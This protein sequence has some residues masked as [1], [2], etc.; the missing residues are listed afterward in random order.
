MA[1]ATGSAREGREQ[2]FERRMSDAEALMWNV[3]KDPW[4]NPSGASISI[5]DR[6][7]DLDQFRRRVAVAVAQVPRLRERV[8][9]G[10]GR[11]SPPEWRTDPEFA[12]D[13][14]VRHLAL[15]PPGS[16]R[17]LFDLVSLLYQDPF[18]R[19]RPLWQFVAIEGLE[20]GRGALFMKLHHAVTDGIGAMRLGEL[21]MQTSRRAPLPDEVDLHAVLS[22]A[23]AAEAALA[24]GGGDLRS[25]AV[26]TVGHTWR[27]QLG[28]VRRAA[29]EVALWGADPLRARD[30]AEGI[31][32]GVQQARSQI[33][34]EG[35]VAGGAPLWKD[36]SR[37]RHLEALRVPLDPVKEA[38]RALGGSVNDLFVTG[39]VV[40]VLA[41]HEERDSRVEALNLSF[42][43]STRQDRAMGGNA[44]TPT[45]LQVSGGPMSAE[46]RFKDLHE[47]M[48]SR[49]SEVKGAGMMAS[50]AGVANLLPTSVVT[51][52]A[53]SQAAKIDFATSNLRGARVPLYVAGAKMLENY[54]IGPVAGTAFNL[55]TISYNG[56]LDMGLLVDPVAVDDPAD[57]RR[58][59]EAGYQELLEA[60][61]VHSAQRR[62]DVQPEGA[63]RKTRRSSPPARGRSTPPRRDHR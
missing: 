25:S 3:E 13:Y 48:A 8:V 23:I 27:R 51:R 44:F 11:F 26:R 49:R 14:H 35:D 9:S 29:G 43:V 16:Q 45:R 61:G 37:H 17:Q 41:Y 28:M 57:L 7:L 10:L 54:P 32:R 34:G 46:A 6:P 62:S 52:V 40:G 53:R 2:R 12:L 31:V 47:R 38:A 5:L 22:E 50:V 63:R 58:C 60:G 55:T 15:P 24:E 59:L 42:V 18:D 33:T 4:L 30:S 19:T 56:S 39:A 21:Y 1:D 36:R 20:E